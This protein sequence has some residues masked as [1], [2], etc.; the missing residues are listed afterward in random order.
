MVVF[1]PLSLYTT[2]IAWQQYNLIY[3]GFLEVGLLLLGF[4]YVAWRYFKSVAIASSE[5]KRGVLGANNTYLYE[6]LTTVLVFICFVIPVVP[7]HET[8][9]KFK[10]AC[11]A[12]N[13]HESK[14]H[15]TG[16][17]YDDVL[18]DVTLETVKIPMA[19]YFLQKV[20][21][22]FTYALMAKSGCQT[23]LNELKGEMVSA[24]LPDS[25][26]KGLG[27]FKNQCYDNAKIRL[28]ADKPSSAEYLQHLKD[29]GG[30]GDLNWMG[31]RVLRNLYYPA[32]RAKQMV[33]GFPFKDN[34]TPA[35]IAAYEKINTPSP[36]NGYP[37]C[38]RWW[39][40]LQQ[41]L[42]DAANKFNS[43]YS[44]HTS[45]ISLQ[46]RSLIARNMVPGK[47]QLNEKE[48]IAKTII[49]FR[50]AEI[51]SSNQFNIG[52]DTSQSFIGGGLLKFGNGVRNYTST[53]LKREALK[54]TLP[55]MQ[56]C[57]YLFLVV[58]FPFFAVL[59][60]YKPKV[61]ISFAVLICFSILLNYF[62][63]LIGYVE[64]SLVG[65]L[66]DGAI[67]TAIEN[68]S[69]TLYFLVAGILFGFAGL[70]GADGGKSGTDASSAGTNEADKSSNAAS[71]L[72]GV[73]K[74]IK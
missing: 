18:S 62:W 24:Y 73:N 15:N 2:F 32:I 44:F 8:E 52:N 42:V 14:I 27:E 11:Y 7:F 12:D 61:I 30:E 19:I 70:L 39:D 28:H 59:S 53:P 48:I 37:T 60:G 65:A 54:Q 9:L 56:A 23:S 71:S 51:G 3:D 13:A 26:K 45:L 57:L 36:E 10:P 40:T 41:D 66:D 33:E 47:A 17:T 29:G 5:D 6:V 21:S 31:S 69:L 4:L 58:I 35:Q 16:T 25:L 38:D 20:T 50:T 46:L 64:K 67:K 68:A 22:A 49:N 43:G 55:I 72:P 1:S 74:V 34:A 63:Y